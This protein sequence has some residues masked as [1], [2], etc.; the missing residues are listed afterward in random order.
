MGYILLLLVLAVAVYLIAS[1]PSSSIPSEPGKGGG[2]GPVEPPLF[3]EG[4][5][6]IK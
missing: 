4:G 5:S 6:E 3:G 2:V 1:R